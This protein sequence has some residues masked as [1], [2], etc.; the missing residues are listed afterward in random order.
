MSCFVTGATGFI[1]RYLVRELLTQQRA[2]PIYVLVRGASRAALAEL[3]KWWGPASSA[4]VPIEGDLTSPLCGVSATDRQRMQGSIRHFFHLAAVYDLE[5]S[6]A[7]LERANVAGTRN[8]LELATLLGAGCFHHCSSIAVAGRYDGVFTENMFDEA[9]GLDHPYFRTKHVSESMVRAQQTIAWRIYRPGMVV[10]DSGSG[11]TTK[12]DGP[13]LLFKTLQILRRNIP[14]WLPTL[15]IEGGYVNIV[16]VDYVAR[17]LVY[18]ALRDGLDGRCFHLTDPVPRRAGEVANLFARAGHA[19]LMTLRLDSTLLRLIPPAVTQ[20][21]RE[22][23]PLRAAVDQLLEDLR[24]PPAVLEFF[25]LPTLFDNTATR[26]LLEEEGIRVPALEGYAWRLWDYWERHL[27]PE[28]S[29]ER[30]LHSSVEGK[31]VLITGGSSGIGKA[32]AIKLAAAGAQ[33]LLV[34]RGADKLERTQAEIR[35][36]KGHVRIYPCDLTDDSACSEL[37]STVLRDGGIDLLINNAGHSIRRS[38]AISCE[39]FHDFER[40]MQINYFAALRLTLKLLPHMVANGGGHVISI[41]SIGVLSNAPRFAAYVASKSALEAFTRCAASEYREQNVHFTVVNMPLVQTPMTAPTHAYDRMRLLSAQEAAA[42][43]C[44]AIVHRPPRVVSRLGLF[45]QL[46][47]V[48]A[49]RFADV[50]NHAS[51]RMFPDSSAAKGI[52]APDEPPT[53]EALAF[54]DLMKGMHW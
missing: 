31:R 5:A 1:G 37:V 19:P 30:S 13:Y 3:C 22:H 45:A 50:I 12:A 33:V 2:G 48:L 43:V 27:D 4:I 26:S 41:S 44:E 23:A 18:L 52:D 34:A 46:M 16:P 6:A 38:I 35:A 53:R 20:A 28:L 17:A 15:G 8:A 29:L 51:F 36:A 49:P 25:D 54:A 24:L 11:Y 42:L 32:T 10:G 7:L 47:E 14:A 21:F 39:R 9:H 40:L